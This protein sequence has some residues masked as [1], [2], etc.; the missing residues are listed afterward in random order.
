M[1][2][3]TKI[4]FLLMVV[5]IGI[6]GVSIYGYQRKAVAKIED[7]P[8]GSLI[9][10]ETPKGLLNILVMADYVSF[11]PFEDA[12]YFLKTFSISKKDYPQMFKQGIA[13]YSFISAKVDKNNQG[14]EIK[15]E[16]ANNQ[17]DHGV[18][19]SPYRL[20]VDPVS[21]VIEEIGPRKYTE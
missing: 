15:I 16:V 7:K 2:S 14:G 13:N 18:Y 10:L 9:A 11:Q 19:S 8:L 17:P 5:F 20:L 3:K 6:F 1:K 21:G 12:S 4:F